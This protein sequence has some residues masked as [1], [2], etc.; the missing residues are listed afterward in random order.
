M[1]GNILK[2]LKD[3]C[4]LSAAYSEFRRGS[5]PQIEALLES[6][7]YINLKYPEY[8]DRIVEEAEQF[9]KGKM[10]LC[11]TMGKPYFV[12]N[13]PKWRENPLGDNEFVW[14]LNRMEHWV[15]LVHA[16]YLTGEARYAEKVLEELE[17][18]IDTCPPLEIV[19]DHRTAKERFSSVHPWRSLEVGIRCHS[20]WNICL[21]ALSDR[22]E[23]TEGLF[24]KVIDCLY[25]HGTILYK[26][27]PVIWPDADHNHYLTECIGLLAAGAMMPFLK[28]SGEWVRHAVTEIERCAAIQVTKGGGQIEGCPTYHNECLNWMNRSLTVAA[29]YGISF[30]E[31]YKKRVR[32][33]FLYSM[34]AARPDGNNVPWGDSDAIPSIYEAAIR[35][36]IASGDTTPLKLCARAYGR[37]PLRD[38]AVKMIWDIRQSEQ[39]LKMLE[40]ESFGSEAVLPPCSYYSKSLKQVMIRKTWDRQTASIFFACRTPVHNDHAHIDPNGFDYCNQGV[41]VLVDAGRY[42]YQE[43]PD[44]RLFKGGTYHNTLL[45]DRR[46]AF[47]YQGTWAYGPQQIGDIQ[48]VGRCGEWDYV[49]G[50][51]ANYFPAIHT[52]LLAF[53]DEVLIIADRVDNQKP[54][55]RANLFFHLNTPEVRFSEAEKMVWAEPGGRCMQMTY[56]SNLSCTLLRGRASTQIDLALDTTIIELDGEE[57]SRLYLT[58]LYMG[59]QYGDMAVD[60]LEDMVDCAVMRFHINEEI[61]EC[62]WRYRGNML[63]IHEGE[64]FSGG[65]KER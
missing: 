40:E 4:T 1:T 21:E 64:S 9:M 3:G 16:Y 39:L 35:T 33:M 24:E 58:L 60:C 52:R 43:G 37:D 23:F 62:R 51:H 28:E 65:V 59:G 32:S 7:H 10:I 42:N 63:E 49:C 12:G 17:D 38:E 46:D 22:E 20:S 54:E 30:S 2:K 18:W 48:K 31:N 6:S 5:I 14:Q 55:N 56:S 8:R 15:T 26:V 53:R 50:S 11:G 29:K 25:Q 27:C 13:P 57:G 36:W 19:L 45:I 41:P 61:I 44:R 34:Y 47:E